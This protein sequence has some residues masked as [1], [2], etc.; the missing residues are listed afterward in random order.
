MCDKKQPSRISWTQL[1]P[2][3]LTLVSDFRS[4]I[5]CTVHTQLLLLSWTRQRLYTYCTNEPKLLLV[6]ETD[7]ALK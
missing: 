1:L 4:T 5:Y 6:I 7:K 3:S 2:V